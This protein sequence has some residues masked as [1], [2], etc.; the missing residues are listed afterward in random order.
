MYY[1]VFLLVLIVFCSLK[2]KIIAGISNGRLFSKFKIDIRCN[3]PER[4]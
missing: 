3:F 1:N 4:I 2:N